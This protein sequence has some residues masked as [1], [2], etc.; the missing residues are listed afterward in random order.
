MG[1]RLFFIVLTIIIF[2]P[3]FFSK[4]RIDIKES[5]EILPYIIIEKGEFKSY[6]LNLSK[7][8]RFEI[9]NYF[10]TG[11]WE[12]K[13]ITINFLDKNSSL[14]ADNINYNN[15]SY[16]LTNSKYITDNYTYFSEKALY[17]DKIL[18]TDNFKFFNSKIYGYGEKMLYKDDIIK[19]DKIVY[20]L[21]GF[22]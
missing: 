15:K 13:T 11:D 16:F 22:K 20:F 6:D 17:K 9:L 21:K 4:K 7:K 2:F 8:G 1:I 12:A 18:K 3:F 14:F 19:A 10:A 5:N